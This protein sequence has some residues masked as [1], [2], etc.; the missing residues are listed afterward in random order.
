MK[1]PTEASTFS[2]ATTSP[3]IDRKSARQIIH[4]YCDGRLSGRPEYYS[5]RGPNEGDLNSKHLADVHRGIK[6]ELGDDAAKAFVRMVEVQADMSATAF[7]NSLYRL[8]RA[9]WKFRAKDYNQSGDEIAHDGM[10]DG[11]LGAFI[12]VVEV[13]S[14]KDR[15]P[16]MDQWRHNS[17]KTPFLASVGGKLPKGKSG[18]HCAYPMSHG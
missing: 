16:E 18:W 10:R 7:L 17:I 9:G 8:E 15:N 11:G 2:T 1:K 3:A 13:W 5:G 14:R 4:E 6:T 12:S